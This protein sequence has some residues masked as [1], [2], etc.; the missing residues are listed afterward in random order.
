[1]SRTFRTLVTLCVIVGVIAAIA[2]PSL[3]RA[4]ISSTPTEQQGYNNASAYLEGG[5]EY[6]SYEPRTVVIHN[7]EDY[8]PIDDNAFRDARLNPLSTFSISWERRRT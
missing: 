4:R 6:V 3:L 8:D 7:T 1:M 2:I 5:G